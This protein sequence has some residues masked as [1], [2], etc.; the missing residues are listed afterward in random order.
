MT[1]AELGLDW[2]RYVV[3]HPLAAGVR[4][5]PWNEP[6][7]VMRG[8]CRGSAMEIWLRR[9]V[10]A[11]GA[12]SPSR[13]LMTRPSRRNAAYDSRERVIQSISEIHDLSRN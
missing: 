9:K 7:E 10:R 4:K 8:E 3:R 11:R 12:Q 2:K 13:R 6:T 1:F 5:P